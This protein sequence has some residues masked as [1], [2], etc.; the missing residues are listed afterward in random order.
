MLIKFLKLEQPRGLCSPTH[1]VFQYTPGNGER[2]GSLP[3]A[4]LIWEMAGVTRSNCSSETE[5][6][7]RKLQPARPSHVFQTS[8]SSSWR[9]GSSGSWPGSWPRRSPTLTTP[10]SQPPPQ[11][12]LPPLRGACLPGHVASGTGTSSQY[13]DHVATGAAFPLTG[14]VGEGRSPRSR[15]LCLWWGNINTF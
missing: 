11:P 7:L 15:G 1:S 13:L 10:A 8:Q 2:R 5:L 12:L 3:S 4:L 9:A 14:S 6:F